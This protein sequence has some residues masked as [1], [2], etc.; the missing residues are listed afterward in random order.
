VTT[1]TGVGAATAM[2]GAPAGTAGVPRHL[3]LGPD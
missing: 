2:R 3:A 1:A